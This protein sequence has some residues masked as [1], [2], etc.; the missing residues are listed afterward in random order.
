MRV[1]GSRQLLPRLPAALDSRERC[2]KPARMG[3]LSTL[4]SVKQAQTRLENVHRLYTESMR[5]TKELGRE[6]DPDAERIHAEY[7]VAKSTLLDQ[8]DRLDDDTPEDERLKAA[9]ASYFLRTPGWGNFPLWLLRQPATSSKIRA[10]ARRYVMAYRFR[11]TTQLLSVLDAN[12][13][14]AQENA[15]LA[16]MANIASYDESPPSDVD[17][18]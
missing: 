9:I 13:F 5:R 3:R 10:I 7:L 6:D 16:L 8:L 2:Y 14:A 11:P 4:A 12:R 1:K 15:R 17:I 18:P